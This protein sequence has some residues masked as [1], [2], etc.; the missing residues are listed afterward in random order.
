MITITYTNHRNIDNIY[1]ERGWTGILYLDNT[2]KA[3]DV[4]YISNVEVKNGLD[5]VKSKIVQEEHIIRI[6]ASETMVKVM[7]KLPLCSDVNIEVDDLGSNK[8]F[9]LRFEV[10]SWIGGGAYA[11]CKLTYVINTFVNKNASI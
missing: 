11:Q 10:S 2:P 8:V 7:Q 5:I 1:F 6:V 4:K 9:N 3:S